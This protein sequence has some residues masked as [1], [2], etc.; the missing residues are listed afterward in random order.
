[1][2]WKWQSIGKGGKWGYS[3]CDSF[4]EQFRIFQSR[5][6]ACPSDHPC[7]WFRSITAYLLAFKTISG[8]S[9]TSS[10]AT[11]ER[12]SCPSIYRTEWR[13]CPVRPPPLCVVQW[14]MMTFLLSSKGVTISN[15]EGERA[16]NRQKAWTH[17]YENRKRKKIPITSDNLRHP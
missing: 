13:Q 7:E 6:M 17:F 11:P 4:R 5:L 8:H 2:K 10:G 12:G 15:L 14:L 1:M 16:S 9:W 3:A